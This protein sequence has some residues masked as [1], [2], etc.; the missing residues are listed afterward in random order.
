M[1]PLG[2]K[3]AK[4]RRNEL[5]DSFVKKSKSDKEH[6]IFALFITSEEI[7]TNLISEAAQYKTCSSKWIFVGIKSQVLAN[8][9]RQE[10]KNSEKFQ[11]FS[12][13]S[14]KNRSENGLKDHPVSSVG[15][16]TRSVG[17]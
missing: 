4:A 1:S 3:K 14:G 8:N 12:R 16:I 15:V 10:I 6:N 2:R 9:V 7:S 11:F 13:K 17:R 5:L